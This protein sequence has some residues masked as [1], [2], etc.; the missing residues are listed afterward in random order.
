MILS[1]IHWLRT[2]SHTLL[3]D[4]L[5][6]SPTTTQDVPSSILRYVLFHGKAGPESNIITS[7]PLFKVRTC[8]DSNDSAVTSTSSNRGQYDQRYFTNPLGTQNT[9]YTIRASHDPCHS[10]CSRNRRVCKCVPKMER[11]GWSQSCRLKVRLV[12]LSSVRAGVK[13]R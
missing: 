12:R 7:A 3:H 2:Q 5:W 8:F 4:K 10:N 6:S 1:K 13:G 9:P 11:K